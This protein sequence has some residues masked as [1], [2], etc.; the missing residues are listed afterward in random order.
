MSPFYPSSDCFIEDPQRYLYVDQVK[1]DL[2][3][4]SIISY[5]GD[6]DIAYKFT[7]GPFLCSVYNP[8]SCLCSTMMMRYISKNN[9]QY[10]PHTQGPASARGLHLWNLRMIQTLV[11]GVQACCLRIRC[12]KSTQ[13]DSITLDRPT[14]PEH[15]YHMIGDMALS[16]CHKSDVGVRACI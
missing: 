14:S 5:V 6:I 9:N 7:S 3:I 2:K 10:I 15:A 13:I 1:A 16:R 4:C 12:A 8:C 11:D